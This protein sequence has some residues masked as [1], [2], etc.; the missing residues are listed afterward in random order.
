MF[1]LPTLPY[2]YDALQPHIDARTMEIHHSKHHAGYTKKLN[3]AIEWT[4]LADKTIEELLS[5][6]D[7]LPEDLRQ[8]ICNNGWGYY[9][10]LLFWPSL[11]PDGGGQPSWSLLSAIE[12]TFGSFES[13]QEEFTK[14]SLGLFGSGWSYLCKDG[15]S[16]VIK[17]YSFQETPL[18]D[19]Y[20]PLLWLDVREHAYYLEYQ[21]R[22]ADYVSARWNVVN[23]EEV[24]KR[25][26]A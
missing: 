15:D 13:F 20:T 8:N 3:A 10:H 16:L 18:K 9:N 14:K 19:W 2:A 17:R 5:D 26:D 1:D 24:Q 25:Y 12:D 22:R 4:D 7:S 21:N 6:P 11:S 23:W